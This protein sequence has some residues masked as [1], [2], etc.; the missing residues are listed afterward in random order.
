[1]K[2]TIFTCLLTATATFA[3]PPEVAPPPPPQP[4]PPVYL[5]PSSVTTTNVTEAVA[6]RVYEQK[7]LAGRPP[8]IQPQQAQTVT[9]RFKAAYPKLGNPRLLVYINR[10]LL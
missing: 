3:K 10:E 5:V 9:A 8:L 4:P 6:A 1:M 7:P 2:A